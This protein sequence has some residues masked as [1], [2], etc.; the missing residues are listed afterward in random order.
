MLCERSPAT[1]CTL[2]VSCFPRNIS[3]INSSD[4]KLV[5]NG[6][7]RRQ[8]YLKNNSQLEVLIKSEFTDKL[9]PKSVLELNNSDLSKV[10]YFEIRGQ[11]S[12]AALLQIDC[13]LELYS[14]HSYFSTERAKHLEQ[15]NKQRVLLLQDLARFALLNDLWSKMN[16]KDAETLQ[17]VLHRLLT[18]PIRKIWLDHVDERRLLCKSYPGRFYSRTED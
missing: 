16:F 7:N 14:C 10:L 17:G 3:D 2:V 13:F 15:E 4:F 6:P 8:Y 1:F 18:L 11:I 12:F 9:Y 5:L